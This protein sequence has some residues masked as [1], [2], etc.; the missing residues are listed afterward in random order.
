[1]ITG[2][3]TVTARAI[4]DQLELGPGVITGTDLQKLSDAEVH[5]AAA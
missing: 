1:M 5:R 2:D 3:H 4:A